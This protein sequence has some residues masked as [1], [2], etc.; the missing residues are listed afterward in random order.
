MIDAKQNILVNQ[1]QVQQ[2]QV[3]AAVAVAVASTIR[4]TPQT[5][6]M[7]SSML[8]Q[9]RQNA[10]L[11]LTAGIVCEV[12]AVLYNNNNNNT[13]NPYQLSLSKVTNT[14]TTT[15]TNGIVKNQTTDTNGKQ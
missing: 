10:T 7:N 13:D 12:V 4:M 5:A 8:A 3:A 14:T 6:I 2:V 1:L 15:T 9:N 11:A